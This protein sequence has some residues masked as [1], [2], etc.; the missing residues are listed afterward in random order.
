MEKQMTFHGLGLIDLSEEI[1]IRSARSAP[2]IYTGR[3][4]DGDGPIP[5]PR[6]RDDSVEKA[7]GIVIVAPNLNDA[8]QERHLPFVIPPMLYATVHHSDHSIASG[9]SGLD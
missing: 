4:L 9:R 5:R 7:L 6:L 3:E 2:R 1:M 8:R